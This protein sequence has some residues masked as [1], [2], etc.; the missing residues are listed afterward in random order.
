ME[1][2]HQ[3]EFEE[4]D[5]QLSSS[6]V[7]N[8]DFRMSQDNKI[9]W[10]VKLSAI[11]VLLTALGIPVLFPDLVKRF[12][13]PEPDITEE[14]ST[15]NP[16]PGDTSVDSKADT[17][18]EEPIDP[19]SSG[20]LTE[21][22]DGFSF[23]VT[24]CQKNVDDLFICNFIVTNLR[25]EDRHL[26]LYRYDSKLIDSKGNEILASEVRLGSDSSD[27]ISSNTFPSKIPINGSLSFNEIP[28]GK[29]SHLGF[30]FQAEDSLYV[31]I[32]HK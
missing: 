12:L 11:A 26:S 32:S 10:T 25:D 8:F 23:Q 18:V 15:V 28:P 2:F 27:N 13:Q 3:F 20:F 17:P 4:R 5:R 31:G 29:I 16:N 22:E 1:L 7:I 14:K 19:T 6:L 21:N 24:D 9:H 30:H